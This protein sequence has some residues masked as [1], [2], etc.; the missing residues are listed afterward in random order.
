MKRSYKYFLSL[1]F[2]MTAIPFL[3]IAQTPKKL[4]KAD[5]LVRSDKE[6]SVSGKKVFIV[7]YS[8]SNLSEEELSYRDALLSGFLAN[9]GAIVIDKES[10]AECIA[11]SV[12]KDTTWTNS[13][14]DMDKSN[15]L[16]L[17]ENNSLYKGQYSGQMII[18]GERVSPYQTVE[19]KHVY[20]TKTSKKDR[21]RYDHGLYIIN[22]DRTDDSYLYYFQSTILQ[23]K[24][25][26]FEDV[27]SLM[28]LASNDNFGNNIGD[29]FK[30]I[31]V[32]NSDSHYNYYSD[33]VR[34]EQRWLR[35]KEKG[36]GYIRSSLSPIC[37]QNFYLSNSFLGT[38]FRKS[39]LKVL[40]VFFCV[41]ET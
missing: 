14:V 12:F 36:R 4:K 37:R 18:K 1:L 24:P 20:S 8:P 3:C 21:F 35:L 22:R 33:D 38:Y 26:R 7:A 17:S 40:F 23:S 11:I 29:K 25:C 2:I 15:R 27:L 30:Q 19:K 5:V 34:Q 32:K 28:M 13:W 16:V 6:F 10:D 31:K 9:Q 39:I 41:L